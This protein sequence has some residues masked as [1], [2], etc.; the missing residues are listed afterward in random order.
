M[1]TLEWTW[2]KEYVNHLRAKEDEENQKKE[3]KPL[4]PRICTVHGLSATP[5]S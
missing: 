5:C 3:G 2:F 4:A 1:Y